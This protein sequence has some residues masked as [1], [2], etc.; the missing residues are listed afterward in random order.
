MFLRLRRLPAPVLCSAVILFGFGVQHAAAQNQQQQQ[1]QPPKPPNPFETVP[2]GPGGACQASATGATRAARPPPAAQEPARVTRPGQ[3]AR[4]C[5]RS[6]RVS[7]GA[8]CSPGYVTSPDLHQEGRPV[9]RRE[10]APRFHGAVEQ[11]TFRRP[12]HRARAGQ[13]RL[14]HPF[15]GGG[16]A[17]GAHHQVRRQQIRQ[18]LRHSGSLQ[19][20]QGRLGGRVA[21]R[22]EQSAARQE[23][24]DRSIG[25]AR[26][27]VGHRRSAN[28]P[29]SSLVARDHVQNQRRPEG[30]G[31]QHRHHGKHRVLATRM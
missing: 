4:E 16:A 11:R 6:H 30:Q 15:R 17:R 24:A 26:P 29:R 1:Q 13:G 10:S 27:P 7:W 3:P 5:H 12:P 23:R 14:D 25:R 2:V 28:P 21:V 20:P 9:R 8:P 19:G 18:R 22:S 31:G